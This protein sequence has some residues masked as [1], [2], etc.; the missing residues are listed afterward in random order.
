MERKVS[1]LYGKNIVV[2]DLEIKQVIDH[3][4]VTWNDFD[5]MGI[6]VGC[7]FDYRDG[8][9][10]VY[11]DDNLYSLNKRLKEADIV[12]GFNILKFDNKLLSATLMEH[13][14]KEEKC[15]DLLKEV[16]ISTGS[17]MPKG[18]KLDEVLKATFGLHMLKT[19]N[20][21]EAPIM[22]QDGRMGELISYCLADVRRERIVFEYAYQFGHLKT[23][24]HGIHAM[25]SPI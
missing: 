5:K 1:D 12:V 10:K 14:I 3:K 15:Y 8:D 20:G 19:A 2:Y 25:R 17:H 7:I 16:R 13:E 22:Y 21:A 24:T 9:Y 11:L 23:E 4:N 18:C 6:S